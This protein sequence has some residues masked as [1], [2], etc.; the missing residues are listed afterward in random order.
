MAGAAVVMASS[1]GEPQFLNGRAATQVARL[2]PRICPRAPRIWPRLLGSALPARLIARPPGNTEQPREQ[3]CQLMR[4]PGDQPELI[5]SQRLAG[6][7]RAQ[8]HQGEHQVLLAVRD[9]DPEPGKDVPEPGLAAVLAGQ[10]DPAVARVP[11]RRE[12]PERAARTAPR[13]TGTRTR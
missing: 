7:G 4:V 2:Y 5:V 12:R 9:G 3:Q 11:V 8:L 10:H 13:E 6:R 1:L